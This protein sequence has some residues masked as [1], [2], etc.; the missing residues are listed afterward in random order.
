MN[1][2]LTELLQ[3]TPV[4][5]VMGLGLYAQWKD[6]RRKEQQ[7]QLERDAHKAELKEKNDYIL[8]RDKTT[9]ETMKDFAAIQDRNGD[10]LDKLLNKFDN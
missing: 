4:V 7:F 9:L 10:N 6:A 3:Q 8:E 5:I 1:E 2:I